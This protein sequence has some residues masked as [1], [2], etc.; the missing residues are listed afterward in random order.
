MV[1]PDLRAFVAATDVVDALAA[2]FTGG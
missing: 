2:E 1:M